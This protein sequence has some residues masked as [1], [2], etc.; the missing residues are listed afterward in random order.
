M[1]KIKFLVILFL[2]LLT[3]SVTLQAQDIIEVSIQGISDGIKNS[4][5]RDR[6]EAIMDAK[7]QAVEKAGVNIKSVTEVENF[8]LKKDW[9]QSK[10]EAYLM[11][12]FKIIDIGYGTDGLYHVVLTGKVRTATAKPTYGQTINTVTTVTDIDG[13]TYKTIKI[14]D[15]VWMTENLKVTHYSNGD[16]ILNM[17]DYMDWGNLSSG[18]Y[19]NYGNNKGKRSTYGRLYNWY[20]VNDSRGLAPKGWHVPT[21][22]EWKELEMYLGMGQSQADDTGNRGTNEGGKLKKPGTAHGIT[23]WN[24]PNTGATNESG[25]SALPDGS[26]DYLYYGYCHL[27][28]YYANFWTSTEPPGIGDAFYRNLHSGRSKIYRN[29]GNKHHA[30]S[31]R[32][33]KD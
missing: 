6:D 33:V 16:A 7:L 25:F 10:A 4:K 27:L 24:S 11:P 29:G 12:G 5:R 32:C 14:G 9:I 26:R 30:F 17:T 1:K 19:L 8:M 31:V 15:Q 28:G 13:N 21:D 2:L 22:L 23:H 18:A 3:R 20:A